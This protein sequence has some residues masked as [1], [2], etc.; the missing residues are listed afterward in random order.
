M[1]VLNRETKPAGRQ[2]RQGS[3]SGNTRFDVTTKRSRG[4]LD[5]HDGQAA[6]DEAEW[7]HDVSWLRDFEVTKVQGPARGEVTDP[8]WVFMLSAELRQRLT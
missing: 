2:R 4:A 3:A 1:Y 6:R 5:F 8:E 7:I